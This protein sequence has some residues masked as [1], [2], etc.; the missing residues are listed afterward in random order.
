MV[1][2]VLLGGEPDC[3]TAS[4]ASLTLG[5]AFT[6]VAVCFLVGHV[7]FASGALELHLAESLLLEPI[8]HRIVK[9]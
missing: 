7:L 8:E 4:W 2:E 6:N 5:E 3:A 9:G 1:I